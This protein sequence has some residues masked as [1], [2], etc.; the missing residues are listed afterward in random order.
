MYTFDDYLKLSRP[1]KALATRFWVASI[2]VHLG[3]KSCCEIKKWLQTPQESESCET[4]WLNKS[5]RFL[6]HLDF[7]T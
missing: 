2:Q 6:T 7:L 5:S 1:T 3:A 4:D